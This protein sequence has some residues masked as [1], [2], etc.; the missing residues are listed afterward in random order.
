VI[1]NLK[2][3]VDTSM[4]GIHLS[5]LEEK[6]QKAWDAEKFGDAPLL[7]SIEINAIDGAGLRGIKSMRVDF[8][9]PVTFFTGQNGA[10]K[11]TL[12][13]LAALAYHGVPG[14]VASLA[15][16]WSDHDEGEF[17]YFTFRDFFHRGPGDAAVKDVGLTWRYDANTPEVSLIKKTEK[18]MRYERRPKRA[19][20]FLG[21]SRAVP[22]IEL[23]YLRSTFNTDIAGI[24]PAPLTDETRRVVEKILGRQ[25][26]KVEEINRKKFT[27]RRT[28][29]SG[30]TSFNM[31]A[32][33][34]SLIALLS[35]LSQLPMGSLVVID[36]VETALHPAAQRKLVEALLQLSWERK[37]QIIGSTHS[38]HIIDKLPRVARKLIV[39]EHESHRVVPSPTT[40][41]ALSE[42]SEQQNKELL[43]ICEDPFAASLL[44]MAFSAQLRK[45]VDIQAC[46]ANSELARYARSHLRMAPKA[47]CLIAWDGDVSGQEAEK[48]LSTAEAQIPNVNDI[49]SRLFWCCLPGYVSPERWALDVCRT[50]GIGVVA[51]EFGLDSEAQ[52]IEIL[53]ACGADN[54]HHI[55]YELAQAT[56]LNEEDAANRL[57]RCAVLVANDQLQPLIDQVQRVLA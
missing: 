28:S 53:D 57:V 20:E 26:P 30:Y 3:G 29:E 39:R 50:R 4:P 51:T 33:E 11:S 19:V 1:F 41:L 31:G 49:N 52:A 9:Y 40:M 36:E 43:L 38:H 18:W 12:L 10:G 27:I 13:A 46:G 22:P 45:R 23:S 5:K 15:K 24:S 14:H 37:L 42:I 21:I 32:G 47:R 48:Y 25:Y 56:G 8:N 17:T 55:P 44:T 16:S 34:D 54:V 35:Q 7:K 6:L 2:N